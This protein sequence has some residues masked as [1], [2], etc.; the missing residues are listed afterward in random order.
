MAESHTARDGVTGRLYGELGECLRDMCQPSHLNFDRAVLRSLLPSA[1]SFTFLKS[2][3]QFCRDFILPADRLDVRDVTDSYKAFIGYERQLAEL[4]DQHA[5]LD[6]I[7]KHFQTHAALRRDATLARWLEAE[8]RRDHAA[9]SLAEGGRVLAELSAACAEE[10]TRL[11]VLAESI[12]KL[13]G[14]LE[15]LRNTIRESPGGSLY[16]ELKRQ[17]SELAAKIGR[18]KDVGRSLDSALAN[19][20]RGAREW[21]KAAA[22][23]PLE[24]DAAS[25]PTGTC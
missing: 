17:N 6:A 11:T 20:V 25:V 9:A 18:L 22:A 2:F 8:C 10:N 15:A 16:L 7:A 19:R 24:L 4:R 12:P 21:V 13:R 1:M 5:R 23:L 14:E 3:N